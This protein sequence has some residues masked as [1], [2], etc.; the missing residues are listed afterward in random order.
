M[1]NCLIF[2]WKTAGATHD[3]DRPA[4]PE[5]RLVRALKQAPSGEFGHRTMGRRNRHAGQ[6]GHNITGLNAAPRITGTASVTDADVLRTA[7]EP[8]TGHD[9]Q[10]LGT[11]LDS[12]A[13]VTTTA[14]VRS[15]T[16]VLIIAPDTCKGKC[17]PERDRDLP[18]P[19]GRV[20]PPRPLTRC[21][22][23]SRRRRPRTIY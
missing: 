3:P 5:P 16:A 13:S 17:S 15:S 4:D 2:P 7:G 21:G 6:D 14:G 18:L 20:L 10:R 11:Q 22:N 19:C 9:M 8:D 12:R 1:V 23:M